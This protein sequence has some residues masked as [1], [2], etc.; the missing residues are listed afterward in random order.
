MAEFTLLFLQNHS[1]ENRLGD[2]ARTRGRHQ[3]KIQLFSVLQAVTTRL[4]AGGGIAGTYHST[5][6]PKKQVELVV[7][8]AFLTQIWTFF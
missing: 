3:D 8:A 4:E 1:E 7:L 2:A 6:W 5:P